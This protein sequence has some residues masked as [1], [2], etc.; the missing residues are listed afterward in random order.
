MRISSLK[1][2]SKKYEEEL[3]QGGKKKQRF[4][5]TILICWPVKLEPF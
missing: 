3:F 1:E 2:E 4:G 5:A